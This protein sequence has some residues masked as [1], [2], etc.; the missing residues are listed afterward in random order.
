MAFIDVIKYEGSDNILVFKHP[1]ED[2]NRHAQLI[3]HETQEAIVF[4][5]GEAKTL[6]TPGKYELSSKNIPGLKHVVA[7]FSGGELANHCEVYYF[8]K[9]LFANI[10]WI[11]TPLDIQDHTLKA[12][13]P[14]HAQGAFSVRI[15][16]A[17][18]L[19]K[20][21]GNKNEFYVDDLKS[22]VITK[23]ASE[24]RVVVSN[25]MAQEGISYGEINSHLHRFS[26]EVANRLKG[27]FEEWGLSLD[28]FIFES[29]FIEK[30]EDF[31]KQN[32]QLIERTGQNVEGRSYGEKRMYD[33]MEAQAHNQGSLGTT[34]NAMT[35]MAIGATMGQAYG[36]M[37]N[38]AV[39]QVFPGSSGS[40][41]ERDADAGIVKP[42]TVQSHRKNACKNCGRELEPKWKFC[43]FCQEPTFAEK[44]CSACGELLPEG[45]LFCPNCREP[46]NE[47]MS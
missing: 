25:A 28:D 40:L 29:I 9:A 36:G 6:Y 4:M 3:V 38:G 33:I 22:E 27:F 30:G 1:I 26:D 43:P 32:D 47:Q 7:L 41:P 2:F 23:I 46:V 13:Y 10:P 11:T 20:K 8:N 21:C 14:F 12:Y 17:F 18:D 31:K 37:I 24:A 16:N 42:H 44:T 19:F 45:A 35:G 39:G 34:A 15:I 5:D